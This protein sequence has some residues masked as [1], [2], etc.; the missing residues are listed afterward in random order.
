MKSVP[1]TF[2]SPEKHWNVMKSSTL[3]ASTDIRSTVKADTS[4]YNE[5]ITRIPWEEELML[6]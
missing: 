3:P 1:I 4:D 2:K 5:H 6:L